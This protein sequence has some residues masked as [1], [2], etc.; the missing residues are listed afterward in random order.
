MAVKWTLIK[1]ITD[2][3]NALQGTK[4][5]LRCLDWFG[6][7]FVA[8]SSYRC[9]HR[10]II[11]FPQVGP[12]KNS[13]SDDSYWLSS[14]VIRTATFKEAWI[15]HDLPP[16]CQSNLFKHFFALIHLKAKPLDFITFFI[17]GP[18]TTTATTFYKRP[19][20]EWMSKVKAKFKT[21]YFQSIS[22]SPYFQVWKRQWSQR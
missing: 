21:H 8:H 18:W 2:I 17:S 16:K 20:W 22:S 15:P 9:H 3:R 12:T 7:N 11:S 14:A 5:P 10:I 1:T 4:L 13:C 6:L 19:K